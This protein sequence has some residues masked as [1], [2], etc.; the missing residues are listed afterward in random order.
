MDIQSEK[1]KV[2]DLKKSRLLI[3]SLWPKDGVK[4]KQRH[5]PKTPWEKS[6]ANCQ[7]K[8]CNDKVSIRKLK[9]EH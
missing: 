4:P 8:G 9:S 6:T 1:E 7:T 5:F 2:E 3:F